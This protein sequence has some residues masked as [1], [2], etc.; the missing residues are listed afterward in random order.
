MGFTGG[1][2]TPSLTRNLQRK[3]LHAFHG[4][5][6]VSE[7]GAVRV[8][9][10]VWHPYRTLTGTYVEFMVP[11]CRGYIPST[12]LCSMQ[13]LGTPPSCTPQCRRVTPRG[14]KIEPRVV[15]LVKP[16]ERVVGWRPG[17]G[18]RDMYVPLS[19][20][21]VGGLGLLLDYRGRRAESL[22]I[23]SQAV[24]G[25]PITVFPASCP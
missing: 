21:C 13:P 4:S 15:Y 12:Q 18:G 25:A 3:G 7:N 20:G 10:G 11:T 2:N 8:G 22:R 16:W 23:V 1:A 24:G 9:L 5:E 17:R 14:Q 6:S 19:G